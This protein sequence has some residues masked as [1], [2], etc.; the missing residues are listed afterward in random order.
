MLHLAISTMIRFRDQGGL[1]EAM[2]DNGRVPTFSLIA[3]RGPQKGTDFPRR[4]TTAA[5]KSGRFAVVA[6]Q[7]QFTCRSSVLPQAQQFLPHPEFLL[8]SAAGF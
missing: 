7:A 6:Q 5:R 1:P 2:D 4:K 3:L 8:C